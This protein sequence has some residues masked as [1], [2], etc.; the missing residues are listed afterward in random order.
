MN[1]LWQRWED[2][3][4]GDWDKITYTYDANN[5]MIEELRELWDRNSYWVN[6]W[7]I[8]YTYDA[9]NNKIEDLYQEWML[10]WV[11]SSKYTYTYDGNNNRIEDLFQGWDGSN[12]ETWGKIT[13]T[14]DTNNNMIEFDESWWAGKHTFTYDESNNMIEDLVIYW[15]STSW[16]NVSRTISTY[17]SVTNIEQSAEVNETYNLSNNYPN[18][19]N[20]STTIRYEI[21]NIADLR[22]GVDPEISGSNSL[23]SGRDMS[24][25][26]FT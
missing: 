21:P 6:N 17:Q 7:K 25:S 13:Y 20:P 26:Q 14:N 19:F 12:W 9:N 2:S 23:Q 11:N 1:E 4:W 16:V 8:T 10:N 24:H 18:P 5:N 3:S 15:D 22:T